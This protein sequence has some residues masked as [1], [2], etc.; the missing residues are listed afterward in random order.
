MPQD[1][2]D[3]LQLLQL[4]SGGMR[5]IRRPLT[6]PMAS[7]IGMYSKSMRRATRTSI[8]A[9]FCPFS[10][11]DVYLYTYSPIKLTWKVMG[12]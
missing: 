9:I 6:I 10:G 8:L 7:G 5:P 12:T 11:L 1:M 3:A 4:C 2:L